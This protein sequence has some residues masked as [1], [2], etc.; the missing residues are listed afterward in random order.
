MFSKTRI[1]KAWLAASLLTFFAYRVVEGG[2][3][4][5]PA[6]GLTVLLQF[7][8]ILLAAPLGLLAMIPVVFAVEA[9]GEC[10]ELKWLLDWSTV[11]FFGYLQ[12][13]V[14]VPEMRKLNTLTFLKLDVPRAAP[15]TKKPAARRA[16]K[17]PRP[18]AKTVPAPT[19][20]AAAATSFTV[21]VAPPREA[22]PAPARAAPKE[23]EFAAPPLPHFDE[24]GLTPL[25]KVLTS[26]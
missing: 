16:R 3:W 22:V 21:A 15:T 2:G 20:V 5:H 18:R 12:W 7:F 17:R 4:E 8:M 19:T 10:G 24:D 14:L 25:G 26:E 1:E 11:L 6:G 9:C 23:R 13:F